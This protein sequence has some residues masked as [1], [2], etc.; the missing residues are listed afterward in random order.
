[1]DVLMY[2]VIK[3]VNYVRIFKKT[4]I[5]YT[6]DFTHLTANK[7]HRECCTYLKLSGLIEE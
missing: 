5:V 6:S 7:N 4:S 2:S 3:L 1:M